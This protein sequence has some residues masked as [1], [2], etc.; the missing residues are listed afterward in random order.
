MN[1]EVVEGN[2]SDGEGESEGYSENDAESKSE[3]EGNCRYVN[4]NAHQSD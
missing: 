4:S 1:V 3:G 2:I